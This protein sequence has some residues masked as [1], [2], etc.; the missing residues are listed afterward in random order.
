MTG[1][2]IDRARTGTDYYGEPAIMISFNNTATR[3]FYEI[4]KNNI[5][6]KLAIVINGKIIMAPEIIE[7]ISAGDIQITGNFSIQEIE[8]A[9]VLLN[10]SAYPVPVEVI[11]A[12]KAFNSEK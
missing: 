3:K 12:G 7:E 11:A 4:T 5:G 8:E 9:V 1:A 10:S 2:D 6:K